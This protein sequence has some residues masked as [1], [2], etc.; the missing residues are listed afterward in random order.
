MPAIPLTLILEAGSTC[1]GR[2]L[3]WSIE[4]PDS[5]SFYHIRTMSSSVATAL[6]RLVQVNTPKDVS[7]ASIN[8]CKGNSNV[9]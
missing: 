9:S 6:W 3:H 5:G 1:L 8:P 7:S 4:F 2:R